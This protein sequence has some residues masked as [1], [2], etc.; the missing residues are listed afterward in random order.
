[1]AVFKGG[2]LK[3]GARVKLHDAWHSS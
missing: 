1:V 3:S 2:I